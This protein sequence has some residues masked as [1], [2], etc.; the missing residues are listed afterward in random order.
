MN[1][2]A[3]QLYSKLRKCIIDHRLNDAKLLMKRLSREERAAVA[4]TK[5]ILG[6]PLLLAVKHQHDAFVNFLLEECDAN[7]EQRTGTTG[8]GLTPL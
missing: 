3:E 4:N 2:N 7:I 5:H 8:N 6:S 1:S